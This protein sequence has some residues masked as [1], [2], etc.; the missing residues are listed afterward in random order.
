MQAAAPAIGL[1]SWQDL[2]PI[3]TGILD[4]LGAGSEEPTAGGPPGPGERVRRGKWGEPGGAA[5]ASRMDMGLCR[6]GPSMLVFVAIGCTAYAEGERPVGG[7]DEE[8]AGPGGGL[9]P[10]DGD[11]DGASGQEAC[12][13]QDDDGDLQVDEGCTCEIGARQ[14]C[15]PGDPATEGVGVCRS[16]VQDCEGVLEIGSWTSCEGFELPGAEVCDD[17][18]D[19]DCDGAVDEDCACTSTCDEPPPPACE[20]SCAAVTPDATGSCDAGVCVYGEA[21][22]D[23]ALGC[24]AATGA[25]RAAATPVPECSGQPCGTASACGGPCEPGSG[26]C[27]DVTY[28]RSSGFT[29]SG[30]SLCCDEGHVAIAVTDCG[31]GDNHWVSPSGDRCG[32]AYEGDGNHGGPCVHVTCSGSVCPGG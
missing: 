21:R 13:G 3:P 30:Y 9:E 17:R 11:D 20:G 27:E 29:Y 2:R 12:D 26:C 10:H 15:Y 19:N 16:G 1:T 7:E 4:A 31:D 24:D 25:C 22:T 8:A 18:L 28:D 14:I 6:P 32:V 5:F 23:C